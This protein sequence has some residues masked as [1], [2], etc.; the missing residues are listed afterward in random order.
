MDFTIVGRRASDRGLRRW[1]LA[2]SWFAAG[3]MGA[4]AMYFVDPDEGRRRRGVTRDRAAASVRVTLR[5]L[6]RGARGLAA[7]TYG[8]AQQAKHLQPEHWSVPNDATLAQR[9]ETELFRD[10]EIPKGRIN[11][12][13]EA[14]II[15]LRGELDR[16]EQIRLVEQA[17]SRIAG[18][19][20]VHNLLHLPGTPAPDRGSVV[21]AP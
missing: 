19:R 6:G 1:L 18:V 17:V 3:A 7:E 16:P 20:G 5:A 15:V 13:A 8:L 2:S 11:I 10:P 12:N 21:P 4:L 9:V 14:G